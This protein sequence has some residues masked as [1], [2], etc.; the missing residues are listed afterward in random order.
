MYKIKNNL[1]CYQRIKYLISRLNGINIETNLN[2]Y[3]KIMDSINQ[4]DFS[5]FSNEEL[6][7]ITEKLKYLLS[8]KGYPIDGLLPE[9][10][11]A[12]K[13][14]CRRTLNIMPFDEQIISGIVLHYG[15]LA[16]MKTGEGK[17]LAAVF[18]AYLNAL[19]DKSVFIMT[20][21][22]YLAKRDALWMNPVFSLL[23]M[24][25]GFI[26][27]NMNKDERKIEYGRN[28]TYLT[29]KEAGFDFLKDSLCYNQ[30]E[31]MQKQFYYAIVD[32]ADFILID[33][34]RFPLV[35]ADSE[36]ERMI[37]FGLIASAVKRLS[38]GDDYEFDP[39]ARNV[40]LTERG[41][42]KIEEEF[43]CGNIYDINNHML[44]CG[45]NV[46]LQAFT[47][48]RENVNYIMKDGSVIVI[49]EFTGRIASNRR[50]P[51]GIHNALEAKHGLKIKAEGLIRNSITIQHFINLFPKIGAVTA[52]AVDAVDDFSCIY[53]LP[54][55]IIPPH[56]PCIRK[57]FDDVIFATKSEKD[58]AIIN[59]IANANGKGQPVLIGSSSIE[60]SELLSRLLALNGISHNILNAKNDEK[61][62]M[63][64]EEAGNLFSVTIST[65]M[66]GRGVD[67]KLGGKD[68]HNREKVESLG[69]LYVIGTTR[70]DNRRIDNQLIGRAGRQGDPG[71]SRFYL[72]MEDELILKYGLS[73][74]MNNSKCDGTKAGYLISGKELKSAQ[75]ITANRNHLIMKA[76]Y[77]YSG[78]F[79]SQRKALSDLR[80][81]ILFDLKSESGLFATDL[82]RVN[83]SETYERGIQFL[84]EIGLRS[85]EKR[86]LLICIDGFWQNHI[87]NISVLKENLHLQL[88]KNKNPLYD[89]IN[90]AGEIFINGIEELKI[91]M[92]NSFMSLDFSNIEF[93]CKENHC[94]NTLTYIIDDNSFV[95]FG[96]MISFPRKFG[97]INKM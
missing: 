4:F 66:A 88:F 90:E 63:I 60:E 94:V 15:K 20:A 12:V 52:T 28:I 36:D 45:I 80:T 41:I 92:I 89:F 9:A 61:E 91:E 62:A 96:S 14:A 17:T 29:V 69:G 24:N 33:E 37:D 8:T 73:G 3:I 74:L 53:G 65:N 21:N 75:R 85:V 34:A 57:D 5:D 31:I 40:F 2:R 43:K 58:V 82:L 1:N 51:H 71:T 16:E 87:E 23:G 79:E 83:C 44:L 30:C 77:D 67:I 95:K 78:I 72:S 68:R 27:E 13:E 54:V 46:T 22:S 39:D 59:D 97:K 32:E 81:S 70:F 76:L 47:F 93:K 84:G 18:S 6:G 26:S 49:D 10:Y 42:K 35:I 25:A 86:I 38:Y 48:Y 55:V 7:S 11:A 64:I 56:T 19:T 50:F